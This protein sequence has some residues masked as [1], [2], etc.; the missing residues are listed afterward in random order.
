M[1]EHG[2]TGRYYSVRRFVTRLG[3]VGLAVP[4]HGVRAGERARSIS[5]RRRWIRRPDGKRRPTH[6]FRIV[7]SHSRK[8]YSEVVY[9]QTTEDFIRCLENAFWHFGGVPRRL[10]LDNLQGRREEG[11]L[12]RSGAQ[13]QGAVVRASTTA[14]CFCR[15]DRT[16]RD[17]RGRSSAASTTSRRTP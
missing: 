11:R 1:S 15:R 8:A 9:R 7:L 10:V 13:P 3:D 12:V 4:S 16:R 5:A 6:V 14:R 17:T 2:F